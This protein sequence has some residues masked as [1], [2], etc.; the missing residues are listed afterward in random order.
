MTFDRTIAELD[1]LLKADATRRSDALQQLRSV[2]KG[3]DGGL[4]PPDDD[5]MRAGGERLGHRRD[6]PPARPFVPMPQRKTH[7]GRF[8]PAVVAKLRDRALR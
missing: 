8:G 5:P 2:V 7:G 6:L 1:A 3:L 4:L